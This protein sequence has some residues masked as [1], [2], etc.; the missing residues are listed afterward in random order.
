MGIGPGRWLHLLRIKGTIFH[1]GFLYVSIRFDDYSIGSWGDRGKRHLKM[2]LQF[3][4][5]TP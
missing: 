1:G 4:A 3:G 5:E 2:N